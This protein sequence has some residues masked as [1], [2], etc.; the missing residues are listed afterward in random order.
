MEVV[1]GP[2]P[3]A[4]PSVLGFET[5]RWNVVGESVLEDGTGAADE[6]EAAAAAAA[7]DNE[8]DDCDR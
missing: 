4:R 5:E 6:A 2:A 3:P 8:L 7:A 1:S